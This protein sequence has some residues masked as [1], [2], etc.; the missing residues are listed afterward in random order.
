[1]DSNLQPVSPSGV[2]G[3]DGEI[4][5]GSTRE[6]DP[7]FF[8]FPVGENMATTGY[9]DPMTMTQD[10]LGVVSELAHTL[11]ATPFTQNGGR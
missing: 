9:V 11:A 2:R 5:A 8:L 7:S 4:F 1:M 3:L 6:P 10:Q